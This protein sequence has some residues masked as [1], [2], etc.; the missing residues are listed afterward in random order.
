MRLTKD[1]YVSSVRSLTAVAGPIGL[2]GYLERNRQ[3]R[4]CLYLRSLFSIYDA[5]D[6]AKLDLPWWTFGAI[7]HVDAI[8][9]ERG[10]HNGQDGRTFRS[11]G[12]WN[13]FA[14]IRSTS[15]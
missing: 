7:D 3:S 15:T 5:T 6:L 8:L 9:R 13:P 10:A 1:I 11:T 4:A 2:L 14:R 12:M